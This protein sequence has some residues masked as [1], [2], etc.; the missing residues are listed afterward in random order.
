M[1]VQQMPARVARKFR[2]LLFLCGLAAFGLPAVANAAVIQTTLDQLLPG[3][4]QSGGIV[5]GDKR[6]SA[7]TYS[8]SGQAPVAARDVNV[9]I[10]NEGTNN[11]GNQQYTIQFTFGLDAFPGE[12]ND[13]VICYQLDVLSN[14]FIDEVGL[15]FNGSVPS[16]GPGN[17]AASV[18]ETVS[19]IDPDGAGPRTAPPVAPGSNDSTMVLDVFN[20]GPGRLPNDNDEFQ[21]VNL[22]RSLLFCKDILVSSQPTGGYAAISIVDNVVNQV[23]EPGMISLALIG[24]SALLLRRRKA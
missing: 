15:R 4:N 18:I 1:S 13:L 6:Y 3:G 24:G 7:F 10:S 22:T 2:R 14:D 9:R 17:A 8:S 23:P 16:Q 5:I 11:V 12:R 21:D 20:D 19:T